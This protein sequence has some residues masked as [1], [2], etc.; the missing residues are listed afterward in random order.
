MS[1]SVPREMAVPLAY[2]PEKWIPRRYCPAQSLSSGTNRL[3]A[4]DAGHPA[5]VLT[6]YCWTTEN[7]Y[8]SAVIHSGQCLRL[9][10][11][12]GAVRPPNLMRIRRAQKRLVQAS[13]ASFTA[14][15]RI[16]SSPATPDY[17]T[18]C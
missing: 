3:A 9:Q 12:S 15:V 18:C 16:S 11:R 1:T 4:F 2:D 5:P 13:S 8:R 6:A 7:T 17:E 14:G 10:L